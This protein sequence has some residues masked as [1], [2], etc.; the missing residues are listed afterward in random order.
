MV[1]AQPHSSSDSW[2]WRQRLIHALSMAPRRSAGAGGAAVRPHRGRR[3][4]PMRPAGDGGRRR[5][6]GRCVPPPH[7]PSTHRRSLTPDSHPLQE[8]S[9]SACSPRFSLRWMASTR[10]RRQR[11]G[12][13]WRV[14]PHRSLAVTPA[15]ATPAVTWEGA[16]IGSYSPAWA[17]A[18]VVAVALASAWWWWRQLPARRAWIACVQ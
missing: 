15:A 10:R 9:R 17:K 18:H 16:S 2:S 8:A 4:H 12:Q 7:P 11:R 1:R 5:G 14:L 3:R 13:G 6:G